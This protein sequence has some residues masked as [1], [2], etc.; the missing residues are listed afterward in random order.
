MLLP[1]ALKVS[2]LELANDAE[3]HYESRLSVF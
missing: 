3:T 2:R 1:A